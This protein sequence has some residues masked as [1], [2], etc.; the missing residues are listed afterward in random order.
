MISNRHDMT[1]PLRH[2]P[3]S[4][5]YYNDATGKKYIFYFI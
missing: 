2:L 4:N 3:N 5:P 1:I